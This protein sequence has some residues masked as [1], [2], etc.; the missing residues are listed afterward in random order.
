MSN[1]T[2]HIP[3]WGGAESAFLGVEFK[4]TYILILSVFAALVVGKVWGTGAYLG[5]PLAGYF[6]NKKYIEWRDQRLP[7]FVR[8]ELYKYGL[9]KYSK[10]FKSQRASFVGDARAINPGSGRIIAQL[11]S[12][13]E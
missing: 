12:P 9:A 8:V 13:K 2:F 5:I 3:K 7:G 10:G 4:D 1:K 11:T 6:V